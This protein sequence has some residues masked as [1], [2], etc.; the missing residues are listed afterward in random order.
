MNYTAARV[1]VCRPSA[2]APHCPGELPF[3]VTGFEAHNG[4]YVEVTDGGLRL[5]QQSTA[6]TSSVTPDHYGIFA[7]TVRDPFTG[8]WRAK[9]VYSDMIDVIAPILANATTPEAAVPPAIRRIYWAAAENKRNGGWYISSLKVEYDG[10]ITGGQIGDDEVAQYWE[11]K[12]GEHITGMGISESGGLVTVIMLSTSNSRQLPIKAKEVAMKDVQDLVWDARWQSRD[13]TSERR[14]IGLH[15]CFFPATATQRAIMSAGCTFG[16]YAAPENSTAFACSYWRV[17]STKELK[18][19]QDDMQAAV[20]T[21]NQALNGTLSSNTG[22]AS[23][24]NKGGAARTDATADAGATA[25]ATATNP[26]SSLVSDD[27]YDFDEDAVFA[28]ISMVCPNCTVTGFSGPVGM[29]SLANASGYVTQWNDTDAYE[30]FGAPSVIEFVDW[31][32]VAGVRVHYGSLNENDTQLLQGTNV[33]ALGHAAGITPEQ[34]PDEAFYID[35]EDHRIVQVN[36]TTGEEDGWDTIC[37]LTLTAVEYPF[38]AS[39]PDVE[40]ITIGCTDEEDCEAVCDHMKH[41]SFDA[42][43]GQYLAAL[44]GWDEAYVVPAKNGDH[45]T[46][47]QSLSQLTFFWG[48]DDGMIPLA[49]ALRALNMTMADLIAMAKSS[50]RRLF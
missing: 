15:G 4:R 6:E 44:G 46:K 48:H 43:E 20:D 11:L 41:H 27:E 38:N 30:V 16:I 17:Q 35:L 50:R 29:E 24:A 47:M 14:L 8:S 3:E 25:D 18:K 21:M 45:V 23:K 10:N 32:Y 49:D 26:S 34:S 19:E 7:P 5:L 36:V 1:S 40:V 42:P 13:C 33:S 9:A 31:G 22:K 2:D 28:E 39:N 37:S 12:E